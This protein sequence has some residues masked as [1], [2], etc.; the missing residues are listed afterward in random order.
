MQIYVKYANIYKIGKRQSGDSL[1]FI[2]FCSI[3]S[4]KITS[5]CQRYKNVK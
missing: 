5:Q 2:F 1:Y 4:F 3:G